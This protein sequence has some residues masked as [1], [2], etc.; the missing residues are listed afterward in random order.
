MPPK[1]YPCSPCSSFT[2]GESFAGGEGPLTANIVFVGEALG[3]SE[4]ATGRPF[5]GG[6][7]QMLRT[8]LRQAG[9]S[10]REVYITNTV[11]CR[12]PENRT[13]N[14]AEINFCTKTYLWDELI[15]IKP[16]VIVPVGNTA[17]QAILPSTP[18]GITDVRGSV[19]NS[20]WGKIIPIVHPSFV[21]Q[22]NPEYWAITVVDLIHIKEE[23]YDSAVGR[24]RENFNIFPS[25]QDVQQTCDFLL[26]N[27]RDFSFDIETLGRR[28]HTNLICIGFAWSSEDALCIPFLKRGGYSYWE[29]ETD[30]FE[31]WRSTI[32]LLTSKNLKIT[33]NGFTFDLPILAGLRVKVTPPVEDTLVN[34]HIVATELPHSLAFLKS[35]Y[36]R[37]LPYY[38]G[39]VKSSGGML[40]AEDKVLRTYCCRD[41][42]S[43]FISRQEIKKEMEELCLD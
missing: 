25:L 1:P 12:P 41:C 16:N 6:T 9:I 43:T 3:V 40:W 13:P 30:E 26:N 15:R 23:S 29:S 2:I 33:Q 8:M 19:F 28:E 32:Q 10:E 27:N 35:I 37:G 5:V 34:H 21:A 36:A 7:G 22:G 11:K 4:A 42:T 39:D 20:P 24:T 31:V 38:K 14:Q 17:L 18:S